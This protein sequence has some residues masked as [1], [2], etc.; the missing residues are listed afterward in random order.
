ME[1]VLKLEKNAL[2]SGDYAD[3]CD[4]KFDSCNSRQLTKNK[5]KPLIQVVTDNSEHHK[6]WKYAVQKL[7]NMRYVNKET[8]KPLPNA[9][10]L[11]NWIF[12]IKGLEDLWKMLK[13]EGFTYLKTGYINQDPLEN[14]F[15][16]L[17]SSDFRDNTPS[18]RQAESLLKALMITSLTLKHSL[19]ANCH[20]DGAIALKSLNVLCQAPNFNSEKSGNRLHDLKFPDQPAEIIS[21]SRTPGVTV[22]RLRSAKNFAVEFI[23]KTKIIKNF[24]NCEAVFFCN[25]TP[26]N[27]FVSLMEKYAMREINTAAAD[28]FVLGF[29][30]AEKSV[31]I[32]LGHSCWCGHLLQRIKDFLIRERKVSFDWITCI[33][34]RTIIIDKFYDQI[35]I[36]CIDKWC[37]HLNRL[38]KGETKISKGTAME[39][40]AIQSYVTKRKQKIGMQKQLV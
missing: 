10:T 16:N 6:F 9:P 13:K 7:R 40:R 8:L 34:H 37:K 35:I 1:T 30:T 36:Y 2:L 32:Q 27:E 12:T 5:E 23:K 3:V 17:K 31:N 4:Q 26:Q 24:K 25:S 21:E 28:F 38:L 29:C 22:N 14:L 33:E 19:T 39:K 11:N 15:G 18:C 20:D